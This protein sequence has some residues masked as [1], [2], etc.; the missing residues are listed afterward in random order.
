MKHLPLLLLLLISALTA[1]AQS[2]P[3][4]KRPLLVSHLAG[5]QKTMLQKA[6]APK[7]NGISRIICFKFVCKSVI[8]WTRTQQRNKFKG[9]KK[10]GIPRLKYLKNDSLK[11]E[12]IQQMPVIKDPA[13]PIQKDSLVSFIFNDVLFDVNSS[14]IKSSFTSQLDSVSNLIREHKNYRIEV[15]GHTDNSGS[16]SSNVKLS[17]DRAEAVATYLISTGIDEAFVTADGRGSSEPIADNLSIGGRS[18]NRR[19]EILLRFH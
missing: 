11:E 14:H 4:Y 2:I 3:N 13:E 15:I 17:Q 5:K 19:V 9:Y 18:K 16:E 7:H 10:P 8:G 1:D 6:G 12:R